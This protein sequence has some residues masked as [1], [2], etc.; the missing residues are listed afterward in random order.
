MANASFLSVEADIKEP[1]EFLTELGGKEKTVMRHI[2]S[3]IGTSAKNEAKRAYRP[4]GLSKRSGELYKSITRKV[5]KSGKGVIVEAKAR[6]QKNIFYGYALSK[7]STIT[8]KNGRFL[9]FQIDV[10]WIRKHE[11]KL[12][13][14]NFIV[15]PVEKY[16]I[17]KEF[18]DRLD[19]LVDREVKKIEKRKAQ[20]GN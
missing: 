5:L 9:T 2:L 13:E 4:A 16:L 18:R 7:G 20:N 12:T 15:A 17:S 11:V 8:A 14:T 1:L 6:S 3:G 10:K 19:V